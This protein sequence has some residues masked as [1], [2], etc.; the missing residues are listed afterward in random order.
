MD[1]FPHMRGLVSSCQS[2]T[3]TML[4]SFT[5]GVLAPFLSHDVLW[6]AAG[7]LACAVIAL[8]FWLIGAAYHRSRERGEVNAWEAV[9]LE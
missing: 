3:Q 2:F 8:A 9:P 7:Q 1:L 4:A 6:L 5:A